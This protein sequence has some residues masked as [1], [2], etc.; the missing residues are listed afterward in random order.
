MTYPRK[1]FLLNEVQVCEDWCSDCADH[2]LFEAVPAHV[3]VGYSL[4][5]CLNCRSIL[6]QTFV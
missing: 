1:W 6:P 5:R 3:G 4:L 2:R